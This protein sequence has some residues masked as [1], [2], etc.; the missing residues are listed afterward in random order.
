MHK[1]LL[2]F[3]IFFSSGPK[4]KAGQVRFLNRYDGQDDLVVMVGLGKKDQSLESSREGHNLAREAVR[5]S[6]STAIRSLKGKLYS[7]C[8]W[9]VYKCCFMNEKNATKPLKS[10]GNYHTLAISKEAYKFTF[11]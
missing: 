6:I 8:H 2:I 1:Y 7:S 3:N 11:A 10:S 4:L 5:T 9:K